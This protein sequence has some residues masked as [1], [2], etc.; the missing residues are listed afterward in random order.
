MIGRSQ[1]FGGKW[2]N[3]GRAGDVVAEFLIEPFPRTS[4]NDFPLY[5]Q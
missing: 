4:A 2:R 1:Q 3:A 5:S